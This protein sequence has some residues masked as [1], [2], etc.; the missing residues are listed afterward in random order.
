MTISIVTPSYN[1]LSYLKLCAVSIADQ[2]DV[3]IEHI[4]ID[5]KSTDGTVEWLSAQSNIRYISEP[6]NGM[7]DALNKGLKM[8]SGDILAYLNCDEQYLPGILSFVKEYFN[9]HPDVDVLFGDFLVVNPDGSLVSYRKAFQPRR[10]YIQATHLYV[11]TCSMFFRRKLIDEGMFFNDKYRSTADSLF[12]VD[13]LKKGYNVRHV[14]HYMSVFTMTGQNKFISE[15]SLNEVKR[16]NLEYGHWFHRIMK[17]PL[18]IMR[19]TE[20][21]IHGCYYEKFPITYL[22][23]IANDNNKRR[24]FTITEGSPFWNLAK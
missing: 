1:M 17:Q 5:A 7:Y 23:Y 19:I 2:K 4:V 22:I 24:K 10:Y 9:T 20:K 15:G 16:M 3:Q 18:N 14:R 12:V 21:L 11:F 13:I 8:A 6:D